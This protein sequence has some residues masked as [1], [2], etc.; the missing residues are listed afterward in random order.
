MNLNVK[1][2]VIEAAI[3]DKE[4]RVDKACRLL[5]QLGIPTDSL[6]GQVDAID[7]YNIF[8]DEEKLKELLSKLRNKAFW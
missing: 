6:F 7:L 5:N 2:E 8:T 3:K 4:E 1:K